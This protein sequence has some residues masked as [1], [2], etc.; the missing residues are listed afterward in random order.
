MSRRLQLPLLFVAALVAGCSGSSRSSD[1]ASPAGGSA[2]A[3]RFPA[4]GP[5]FVVPGERMTYRVTA[6]EVTLAAF[7]LAVGPDEVTIDGRPAIVVQAG[8]ESTGVAALVKP[9]K[10]EFATWIDAATGEPLVFRVTETAGRGDESVESNEASFTD[11]A[12]GKLPIETK[13]PD[14]KEL[15]EKQAFTPA[16]KPID[17]LTFLI[18]LRAWDGPNGEEHTIDVVRSR[19]VWRAQVKLV[20]RTSVV[21]DLGQL[22]AV[23]FDATSSRL[24]R[25]G[26]LDKG[27]EPRHFT[28]WISDDADRVPLLMVAETDYGDIRMEIVDYSAGNGRNLAGSR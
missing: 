13:R 15:L 18:A 2:S 17:T 4:A 14:G 23:K 28:M 27:T 22:P 6:H 12:E 21:T 24:M 20:G 26:S 9:I 7:A 3:T 16:K 5:P 8:A 11:L 25:D 19:Y 10:A 1:P